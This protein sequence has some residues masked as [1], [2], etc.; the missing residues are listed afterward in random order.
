MIL[1]FAP[2]FV[3]FVA[4]GSKPHTLRAGARWSCQHRADLYAESRRPKIFEGSI[5]T[6][7]MKLL[8]RAP[9]VRVQ[10]A[11]IWLHQEKMASVRFQGVEAS[12]LYTTLRIAFD[13]VELTKDETEQFAWTDGF[14]AAGPPA[15]DQ[16]MEFWVKR[17]HLRPGK[18]WHGQNIWWDYA[19][20]FI[21][22]NETCFY[23][24]RAMSRAWHAA[25]R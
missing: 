6:G 12:L 22:I 16:M 21:N 1:G 15:I 3:P 24:T 23:Q 20:R 11:A 19:E 10:R 2:Q 25:Q 7:G 14:R 4:D 13:G 9:V 5:Q 8:F 18:T 17:N